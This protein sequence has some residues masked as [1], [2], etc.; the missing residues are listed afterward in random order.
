MYGNV[1][2]RARLAAGLTQAELAAIAGQ[3]QPNISAIESNRR[4]PTLDTLQRLLAGCGHVLVAVGTA[5][6]IPLPD[7]DEQDDLLAMRTS[8]ARP[9]SADEANRILMG[10][11]SVAE[12]VVRARAS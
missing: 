8:P 7:P 6:R 10:A 12:A 9:A 11:L 2:R 3:E 5:G 4:Q 1:V